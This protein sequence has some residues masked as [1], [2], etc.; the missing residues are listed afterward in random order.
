MIKRIIQ[1]L[2][3]LI[4]IY[5]LGHVYFTQKAPAVVKLALVKV[6][7]SGLTINIGKT[8]TG[9]YVF[10]PYVQIARLALT[11]STAD[12][13]NFS[14]VAPT[15]T[16]FMLNWWRGQNI[17]VSNREAIACEFLDKGLKISGTATNARMTISRVDFDPALESL[18]IERL[19]LDV[20]RLNANQSFTLQQFR[21]RRRGESLSSSEVHFYSEKLAFSGNEAHDIDYI[22]G[23]F[24][25]PHADNLKESLAKVV[26]IPELT[27]TWR[28]VKLRASG[29]LLRDK[30]GNANLFAKVSV[31]ELAQALENLKPHPNLDPNVVQAWSTAINVLAIA[32]PAKHVEFV[33][34]AFGVHLN[35][36][37]LFAFAH[38]HEQIASPDK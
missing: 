6:R 27:L 21:L 7:N 20:L 3:L 11:P 24:I 23:R 30:Q 13:P 19:K 26:H 2:G 37:R 38:K 4:I 33:V 31:A 25:Y 28:D 9:H 15:P 36:K 18:F 16:R 32:L 12:L 17:T 22:E 29:K 1:L 8:H 14:L 34:N 10:R 5:G 35:N